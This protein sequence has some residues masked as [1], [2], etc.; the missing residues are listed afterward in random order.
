MDMHYLLQALPTIS[1]SG[2]TNAWRTCHSVERLS[3]L[4]T[5]SRIGGQ[6]WTFRWVGK[7]FEDQVV[8]FDHWFHGLTA[9]SIVLLYSPTALEPTLNAGTTREFRWIQGIS[10][11]STLFHIDPNC[12]D[13]TL[14]TDKVDDVARAVLYAFGPI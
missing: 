5:A 2:D 7:L 13:D 6:I 11:T 9:R 12:C 3:C 4:Q 10:V 8:Q 1:R 14:Y